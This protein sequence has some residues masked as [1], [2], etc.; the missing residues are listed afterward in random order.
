MNKPKI[1][2]PAHPN[3]TKENIEWDFP[4]GV[5]PRQNIG[6]ASARLPGVDAGAQCV[7]VSADDRFCNSLIGREIQKPESEAR[8]ADDVETLNGCCQY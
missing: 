7:L 1:S 8:S 2:I 6:D 4:V 5:L 3:H